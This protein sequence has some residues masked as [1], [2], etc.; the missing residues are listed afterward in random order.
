MNKRLDYLWFLLGLGNGWRIVA[1]L[2][3]SEAV[4]LAA[5]PFVVFN[6]LPAMRRDGTATYFWLAVMTIFGCGVAVIANNTHWA[7][8]L[9]GFA[10]T[11]VMACSIPFSHMLIRKNPNG[12]KWVFVGTS[13]TLAIRTLLYYDMLGFLASD[14]LFWKTRIYAWVLLPTIGW[15]LSVPR[16][17]NVLAPLFVAIFSMT[18]TISGRGTAIGTLFFAVIAFIGGRTRKGMGRFSRF[19]WRF[20]FCGLFF[21]LGLH[22]LYRTASTKGWL[23]ESARRKYHM[24]TQGSKSIGRL[25]LGGRGESF[26]GLLACRDKPIIGWGPW[27][28]D[29]GLRYREEFLSKYGTERDVEY[30]YHALDNSSEQESLGAG[31]FLIS[32]HSHITEFWLWYG[33][34]GLLFWVYYVFVLFRYFRDDCYAVPQWFGWLACSIPGYLWNVAFNPFSNRIVLPMAALACLMARAVRMGRFVLPPEMMAEIERTERI[35]PL[36]RR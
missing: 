30:F 11:S 3:P 7:L 36:R 15:Y 1:S 24:Q 27:A 9:R 8:A 19:F 32:C 34:F 25:I 16:I 5:A 22:S 13:I 12:F 26:V 20:L 35:S 31:R 21:T 4:V 17:V 28:M 2:S 29:E 23:G 18:R 6:E 33:I 14:P 10:A